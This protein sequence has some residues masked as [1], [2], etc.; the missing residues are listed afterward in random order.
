M[1]DQLDAFRNVVGSRVIDELLLLADRVRH[2][3]LQHIN[4]TAVGGGVA[5]ILTRMVPLLRDLGIDEHDVGR[6]IE[7]LCP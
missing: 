1:S 6:S 7:R 5:E 4:S 2:L 3:K